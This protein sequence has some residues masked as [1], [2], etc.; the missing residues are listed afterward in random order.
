[1]SL[2]IAIALVTMTSVAV[3]A[4]LL[5]LL[6][7]RGQPFAR[8]AYNLAVY[9]DQLA[10]VERD[11]N[12][13]VLNPEQ[14]EAARAEIGRRIIALGPVSNEVLAHPKPIA[15]GVVAILVM[16]VAALLIYAALGS[17]SLPD[18]PFADRGNANTNVASTAAPAGHVDMT[19]ALDQLRR[20]LKAEP[21][22]LTGWVLLARTEMGLGNYEAGAQAYAR[23]AALSGDRADVMADW[24]EAQVLAADGN[25]TP[26]AATAL[27]A[28]LTN[29]ETAPKAR[30]YLALAKLQ[31]GDAQGA[32]D[33]WR[34]LLRDSPADAAWLPVVRQ[35]ISE[36]E[37]RLGVASAA[38]APPEAAD[39]GDTAAGMPSAATVAAVGQ[40]TASATPEERRAMID[41]MVGRLAA[42]LAKQPGDLAGWT[43]LGR[44]YMVLGEP[45]KAREAY[46]HALTLKPDDAALKAALAAAASAAAGKT[47]PAAPAK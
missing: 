42:R 23:A 31:H 40:A 35:R 3:A 46:A 22:D 44:S 1:M 9:R 43:Q 11:I 20:H 18:A 12:R 41:M 19:S 13:G 28:A 16:P 30:Y 17:P 25:V 37:A 33:A 26:A 2:A 27:K 8:D 14:A 29:P 21:D 34:A 15:A 39:A 24:G 45:A 36:A 38:P 7:G 32:L 47:Q 6:L 5:P 10:E 4:L